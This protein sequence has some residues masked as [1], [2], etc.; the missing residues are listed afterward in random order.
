[1]EGSRWNFVTREDD[2]RAAIERAGLEVL[3]FDSPQGTS[4]QSWMLLG[5]SR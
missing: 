2:A 3:R 1:M 4:R 5:K